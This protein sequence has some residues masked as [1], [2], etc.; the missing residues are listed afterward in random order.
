MT[1][2]S[3][4][5]ATSAFRSRR[6]SPRPAARFS[7]STS[8]PPVVEALNRGESHIEDVAD[9]RWARL[10]EQGLVHATT[11]Y[12]DMRD[13]E[14]ILIALPTPLSRQREPDLSIVE[15]ATRGVAAVLRAGPARRA[16]VD[17]VAGHDARGAAADPR[18]GLGPEGRRR[19]SSSRCRPSGSTRAARTGRRKTTPKVVG[20]ITPECTRRAAAVYRKAIDTVHE[21]LDPGGRR[22]DEAAREHL[23]LGQHRARQRARA[24]S[25]TGWTSTSGR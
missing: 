3:S 20:G 8:S 18:A 6:P 7:S 12:A 16:R 13:A 2:Q 23:P 1:S 19:T 22:A 5:P 24:C 21:R 17:D 15:A 9:D 14:A 10:V 4:A 11:D 25:A